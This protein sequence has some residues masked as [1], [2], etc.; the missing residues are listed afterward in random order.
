[1]N[2]VDLNENPVL[3]N[4]K[5]E[6]GKIIPNKKV[7]IDLKT[8]MVL[9][10]VS[11]RYKII[12]NQYLLNL[13]HPVMEELGF[14]NPPIVNKTKGG[15]VTF[16]KFLGDKITGEIQKGDIVRFGCEFFNSYNGS[17][18]VGFH[19]IA[20]RLVCTNGLV[21]PKSITE[22]HIRHTGDANVKTI[23]NRVS[24]Y[25]PKTISAINLW[26]EWSETRPQEYQLESYLKKLVSNKLQLEFMNK[27]RN[28]PKEKQNLWEFYNI[29]TYYTTHQIKTRKEDTKVLKQFALT[30]HFTNRLN[31]I[32]TGRETANETA[33]LLS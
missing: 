4:I 6:T 14:R 27:Y 18:P 13:I 29:L 15:A 26:K 32:F 17:M 9:G 22:I 2:S 19:I 24:E 8:N 33:N 20:E 1:M 16:F 23:R 3:H 25:F 31:N 11:S 28:L 12:Q 21:V 7:V 30:E 10:I 5:T